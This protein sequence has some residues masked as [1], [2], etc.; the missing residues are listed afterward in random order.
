MNQNFDFPLEKLSAPVGYLNLERRELRVLKRTKIQTISKI[1]A[2]GKQDMLQMRNI[3]PAT[4]ERIFCAVAEYLGVSG[5]MLESQEIRQVALLTPERFSD[6]LSMSVATLDLPA[7]LIFTLQ[8][9]GVFRVEQLIKFRA[10]HYEGKPEFGSAQAKEINRA[11]RLFPGRLEEIDAEQILTPQTHRK[12]QIDQFFSTTDLKAALDSLGL[13]ERAWLT[14]ELRG[15]RLLSFRKIA[16][17]TGGGSGERIRQFINRIC[18]KIQNRLSMLLSFCDYFDEQAKLMR[19]EM[20]TTELTLSAL[21]SGFERQL[22]GSTFVAQ[23]EDLRRLIAVIRFLVLSERHWVHDQFQAKRKDFTFLICLAE[24][25]IKNYGPV[26]EFIERKRERLGYKEIAYTILAEAKRSLHWSDIAEK[27]RQLHK[28]ESLEAD[29]LHSTLAI[30][31][32]LFVRVGPGTYELAE[33]GRQ[34]VE[35]YPDIIA[36]VLKQENQALPFDLIFTRVSAMRLIKQSSFEMYLEMHPR[37][38]KSI[39]NSYGLRGW[40]VPGEKQHL[41]TPAWLVEDSNSSK[42]VERAKTRGYDVDKL[43]ANDKPSF[44]GDLDVYSCA[45]QAA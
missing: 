42:R 4:A 17:Q 5:N 9:T 27:A 26:R 45:G 22:C 7:A 24:L 8:R 38:Y 18:E 36:S 6:P 1:I 40:L 2:I 13:D 23:K 31:K 16:L 33:W 32:D 19:A 15:L 37:F 25:P 34:K 11:L 12:N 30:Y 10:N 21:S 43:I 14:I 39:H 3:G 28:K 41:H 35:A 44:Y 20:T 29:S